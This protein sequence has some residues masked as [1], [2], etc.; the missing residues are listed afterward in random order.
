MTKV[1]NAKSWMRDGWRV[2]KL[3]IILD[4]LGAVAYFSYG[5]YKGE[6]NDDPTVKMYVTYAMIAVA[7][8]GLI[9]GLGMIFFGMISALFDKVASLFKKKEPE[10]VAPVYVAA[11]PIRFN[12]TANTKRNYKKLDKTLGGSKTTAKKATKATTKKAAGKKSTAKTATKKTTSKSAKTPVKK[13][14]TKS[15]AKKTAES[16]A[17]KKSV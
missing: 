11:K 6:L 8:T 4:G 13:S 9:M 14:S 3:A 1:S 10:V 5:L 12:K 15:V 16:K 17:T 2:I 7:L